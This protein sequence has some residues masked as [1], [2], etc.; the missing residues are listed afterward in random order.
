MDICQTEVI[1]HFFHDVRQ[2][3][4]MVQM[5]AENIG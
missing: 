2:G 3:S 1:C 4:S 5:K